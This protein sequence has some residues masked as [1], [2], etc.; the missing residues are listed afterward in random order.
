MGTIGNLTSSVV[1]RVVSTGLFE[2]VG[3]VVSTGLFESVGRVV[4]TGLFESVGRVA[5]DVL[6]GAG[7]FFNIIKNRSASSAPINETRMKLRNKCDLIT[8]LSPDV[9]GSGEL[10]DPIFMPPPSLSARKKKIEVHDFYSVNVSRDK[11]T[12]KKK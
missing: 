8:D 1:G 10:L 12:Y 9:F 4:S 5:S 7:D 11:Q 2:S 3:R 6:A